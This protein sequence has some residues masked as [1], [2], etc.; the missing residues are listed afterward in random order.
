MEMHFVFTDFCD[1]SVEKTIELLNRYWDDNN[2]PIG[3]DKVS[4][5][6]A[7]I[8]ITKALVHVDNQKRFS[9]EQTG[10]HVEHHIL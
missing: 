10:V 8:S 9:E 4:Y 1:L 7:E 5:W 2:R 6:L 3:A